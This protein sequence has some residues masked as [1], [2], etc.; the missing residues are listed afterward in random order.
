PGLDALDVSRLG[1]RKVVALGLE[2]STDQYYRIYAHSVGGGS[3]LVAPTL[4]AIKVSTMPITHWARRPAGVS[5]HIVTSSYAVRTL[6]RNA[7]R[8]LRALRLKR[9]T[10]SPRLGRKGRWNIEP[11]YA[12][13]PPGLGGVL[14]ADEEVEKYPW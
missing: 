7:S 10:F 6:R 11:P 14:K 1:E 13:I 5:D 9:S 12:G 8:E 4:M 2:A 3:Y